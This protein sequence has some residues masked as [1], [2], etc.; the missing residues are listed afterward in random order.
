MFRIRIHLMRIRIHHFRLNTDPDPI[1]IKGFDDQKV[2]KSCSWILL[3]FSS[4]TTTCHTYPLPSIKDV[5]VTE[6]AFSS[7]KRT[8]STT[9]HEIKFFSTILGH[10]CPDS[11]YESGS[12]LDPVPK[13]GA[14]EKTT[15]IFSLWIC[16]HVRSGSAAAGSGAVVVDESDPRHNNDNFVVQYRGENNL[17]DVYLNGLV[18][19]QTFW[20]SF[21]SLTPCKGSIW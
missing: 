1:R 9:K 15:T 6:E 5:E 21:E 4:K 20:G 7:Q 16:S 17:L 3:F 11:E 18:L 19:Y 14:K 8:S 12:N 10:F 2:K 13:H